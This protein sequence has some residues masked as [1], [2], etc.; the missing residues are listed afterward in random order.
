MRRFVKLGSMVLVGAMVALGAR[1]ENETVALFT[2]NNTNPFFQAVRIGAA[3][4]AHS[5]GATVTNFIPTKPDSI[6]E[7]MSQVE[8]VIVK[9]P[10]IIVFIPVDYKAMVPAVEKINAAGIPVVNIVDRMAGSKTVA[11]VGVDDHALGLAAGRALI[12]AMGGKGNVV[13]LEGIRGA[14]SNVDRVRGLTEALKEAPAVKLLASQPANFQRLNALQAMENILQ[15]HPDVDGV[16]AANDSMAIGAIEALEG[17]NRKALVVGI[18][19]TQ[20][21]IDAI[22]SGKLLGTASADPFMQGCLG[23]LVAIRSLRHLPVPREHVLPSMFLSR[24]TY[25]PYDVPV[26]QRVCPKWEATGL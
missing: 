22:K 14:I 20:E 24:D 23:T 10:D 2:K 4:A 6:P 5:M 25:K 9:R 1:A 17:A 12:E 21:A 18:N 3:A 19:G 11:F 15:A 13:I 7:Q 26:E 8:D 16:M